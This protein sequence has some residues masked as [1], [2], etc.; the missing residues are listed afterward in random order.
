ML[1]SWGAREKFN[2]SNLIPPPPAPSLPSL[3]LR[4]AAKTCNRFLIL[5][6]HHCRRCQRLRRWY[7]GCMSGTRTRTR[8]SQRK[9]TL[10]TKLT[11]ESYRI[12]S[13][14]NFAKH[15]LKEPCDGFRSKQAPTQIQ[16]KSL[17]NFNSLQTEHMSDCWAMRNFTIPSELRPNLSIF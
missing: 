3:L 14:D 2:T 15:M 12:E 10:L 17:F 6:Q 9:K 8:P 7:I 4:L 16:G 1:L 13:T 11:T 5:S